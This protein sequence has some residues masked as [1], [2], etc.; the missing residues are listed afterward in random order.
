MISSMQAMPLPYARA[1]MTEHQAMI[2]EVICLECEGLK[3]LLDECHH[4]L[5]IEA[6]KKRSKKQPFPTILATHC[7]NGHLLDEKNCRIDP[8][9]KRKSLYQI[10]RTCI[11]EKARLYAARK[12][13]S[14]G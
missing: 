9:A 3:E 4:C 8:F 10:C 1:A 2:S 13:A 6:E 14:N 5:F 12:K 11:N 7:K